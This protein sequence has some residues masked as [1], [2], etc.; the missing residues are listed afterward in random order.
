MNGN[1]SKPIIYRRI[2]PTPIDSGL[3]LGLSQLPPSACPVPSPVIDSTP[4]GGSVTTSDGFT[5]ENAVC[6]R[7]YFARALPKKCRGLNF[8]VGPTA[9]MKTFQKPFMMV[10]LINDDTDG[11]V[12]ASFDGGNPSGAVT[13][14]AWGDINFPD[15]FAV[16]PREAQIFNVWGTTIILSSDLPD[17]PGRIKVYF[18]Q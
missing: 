17:T 16:N 18:P 9:I 11:Y 15:A 3:N 1:G 13:P 10:E 8:T 7:E 4:C 5:L 14:V 6:D 2:A 12:Y